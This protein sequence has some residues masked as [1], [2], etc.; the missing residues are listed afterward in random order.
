MEK[1]RP[2]KFR[3]NIQVIKVTRA[4]SS[5][6]ADNLKSQSQDKKQSKNPLG[7][8]PA[9]DY[10]VEPSGTSEHSNEQKQNIAT[11]MIAIKVISKQKI[12]SSECLMKMTYHQKR[13]K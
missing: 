9:G 7:H 8:S 11:K 3:Q 2:K 6:S 10:T 13:M 1:N 12:A 5:E 4:K